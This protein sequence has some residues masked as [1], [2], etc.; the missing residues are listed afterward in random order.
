MALVRA[1]GPTLP[2]E[3]V[4]GPRDGARSHI[5]RTSPLVPLRY[6]LEILVTAY[7]MKEDG[8]TRIGKYVRDGQSSKTD[9]MRYVWSNS[10]D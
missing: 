5:L 6:P 9:S 7:N 3:Y 1:S 10:T 4:G 8:E 2:I